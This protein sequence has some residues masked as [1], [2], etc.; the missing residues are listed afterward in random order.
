MSGTPLAHET[1]VLMSGY[2][3]YYFF[4]MAE[5]EKTI[6]KKLG[7]VCF[8]HCEDGLAIARSNEIHQYFEVVSTWQCRKNISSHK[9]FD[10]DAQ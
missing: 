4:K 9:S 5:N 1:N 3:R 8:V 10:F 6:K 2:T 7:H